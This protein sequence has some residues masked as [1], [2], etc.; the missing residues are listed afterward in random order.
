MTRAIAIA[1][2]TTSKVV[3]AEYERF[4]RCENIFIPHPSTTGN[5]GLNMVQHSIVAAQS[6]FITLLM[7]LPC[8]LALDH[9]TAYKGFP[10]TRSRRHRGILSS[11]TTRIKAIAVR[12][13]NMMNAGTSMGTWNDDGVILTCASVPKGL[14]WGRGRRVAL[15]SWKGTSKAI[16][17]LK[18]SR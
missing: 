10:C 9:S 6:C 4:I 7:I 11:H 2:R 14:M 16:S 3:Y 17:E 8:T 13:M 5:I 12:M 18:A 15:C 1:T